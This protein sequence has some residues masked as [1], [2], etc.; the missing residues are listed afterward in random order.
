MIFVNIHK[1]LQI[2]LY[3]AFLSDRSGKWNFS[4]WD[5]EEDDAADVDRANGDGKWIVDFVIVLPV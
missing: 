2:T 3:M 1:I 4:M 5:A